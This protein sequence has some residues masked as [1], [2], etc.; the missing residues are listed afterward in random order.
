MVLNNSVLAKIISDIRSEQLGLFVGAGVSMC[1]PSCLPGWNELKNVVFNAILQSLSEESFLRENN[2]FQ[3]LRSAD[4]P[5]EFLFQVLSE[6]DFDATKDVFPIV[7]GRAQTNPLHKFF[8]R[9]ARCG[10]LR[11]IVTTNFDT[12]IESALEEEGIKF[13]CVANEDDFN[14]FFLF[15]IEHFLNPSFKSPRTSPRLPN[16]VIAPELDAD[17]QRIEIAMAKRFRVPL[18]IIKLHGTVEQPDSMLL[19]ERET[20]EGLSDL[21]MRVL[22][23][24]LSQYHMLYLGY[25]GADLDIGP[26]ICQA[27]ETYDTRNTDKLIVTAPFDQFDAAALPE[28]VFHL[29]TVPARNA[30]W[31]VLPDQAGKQASVSK[32]LSTYSVQGMEIPI[33]L[34][35]L[36]QELALNLP[37]LGLS[38]E[39]VSFK[40][41]AVNLPAD[42]QPL[43]DWAASLSRA[44][45]LLTIAKLLRALGDIALSISCTVEAD[46]AAIGTS[47]SMATGT[48]L[49]NLALESGNR[50]DAIEYLRRLQRR[51][52]NSN[53]AKAAVEFR[54]YEGDTL[55]KLGLPVEA[56]KAF[57]E[58]MLNSVA[59]IQAHVSGIGDFAPA[60]GARALNG[61]AAC[62]A[63]KRDFQSAA[64][65]YE[66]ARKMLNDHKFDLDR[67]LGQRKVASLRCGI[68]ANL[69][70][71]LGRQGSTEQA[72]RALL[73][74]LADAASAQEPDVQL[75]LL[76]RLVRHYAEKGD[77]K[78]ASYYAEKAAVLYRR[79]IRKVG[80]TEVS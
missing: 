79:G 10:L 52:F 57:E 23:F 54:L 44:K 46:R 47:E 30:Y 7:L 38:D 53:D 36:T 9:L 65:A 64:S 59:L 18:V 17:R 72:E 25:S 5:P 78:T 70:Y 56:E 22:R 20:A 66:T 60:W 67:I 2:I 75:L 12:L 29:E 63:A 68:T 3:K 28:E 21:R 45:R 48:M 73:E 11:M 1:S 58:V 43:S 19:T 24:V 14:Q 15:G 55:I 42:T 35:Q 74:A 32:V 34:E 62:L 50:V 71:C 51:M 76:D 41:S 49:L 80:I 77:R 27:R 37:E 40:G 6:I 31:T 69:A 8:A 26:V 4:I 39:T 16:M 33:R 13:V 61:I